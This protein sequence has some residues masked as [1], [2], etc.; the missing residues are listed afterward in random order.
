[1]PTI[2]EILDQ[3][4]DLEKTASEEVP[5]E[6]ASSEIQKIASEMGLFEELFPEDGA[7]FGGEEK[8]A[9]EEKTAYADCLGQRAY[10][11][12]AHRFDH[13]M[14]K[15]AQDI[16]EM[17]EREMAEGI[18][19]P[20]SEAPQSI[21][22]DANPALDAAPRPPA[23]ETPYTLLSG[24][25]AGAEGQVGHQEQQS[26]AAD[27]AEDVKMAAAVQKHLLKLRYGV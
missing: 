25:E 4:L 13:R 5:Q 14:S 3:D 2:A 21:P 10:A 19:A 7:V 11:Y 17:A 12:F 27:A 26:V 22:N 8:T 9:E 18:M 15:V 24:A 20:Q 23:K 6:P 16:G 1:M